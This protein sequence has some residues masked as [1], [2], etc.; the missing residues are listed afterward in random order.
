MRSGMTMLCIAVFLFS[1]VNATMFWHGHSGAGYWVFHSHIASAA[2][3]TSSTEN[4]HNT[5]ELLLIQTMNQTSF[6][7]DVILSCDL[8]PLRVIVETVQT[9]PIS[10][11]GILPYDHVVLRGPPALV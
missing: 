7:E 8:E 4:P 5:A 11:A 1:Y 3:R 6:T 2:H 9:E 10:C